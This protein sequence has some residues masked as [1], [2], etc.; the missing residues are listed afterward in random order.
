MYDV[1]IRSVPPNRHQK[2]MLEPRHG[3]IRLIYIRLRKADPNNPPAVHEIKALPVSNVSYASDII[4]AFEAAKGYTRR[5]DSDI[6]PFP[7]DEELLETHINLIAR[8]IL[9][10]IISSHSLK[11]NDF[12]FGDMVQVYMKSCHEK[13]ADGHHTVK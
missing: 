8:H 7:A 11:G 1:Q 10:R 5:V 6:P 3:H 4:S 9:T 13:G 12:R 2:N